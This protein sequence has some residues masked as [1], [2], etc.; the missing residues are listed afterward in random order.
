VTKYL[1]F[2]TSTGD[3]LINPHQVTHLTADDSA[4]GSKA[5]RIHLSDGTS[6]LAGT[7]QDLWALASKL[8]SAMDT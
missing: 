1:G 3:I 6:Y 8:Q 2:F 7:E 5:C 4:S